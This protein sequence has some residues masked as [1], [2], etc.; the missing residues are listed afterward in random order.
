MLAVLPG[1]LLTIYTGEKGR[2]YA[3]IEAFEQARRLALLYSSN[4][5][6]IMEGGRQVLLAMAQYPSLKIQDGSCRNYFQSISKENP[7]F[8]N[9]IAVDREGRVFCSAARDVQ[10]V[11]V[12]D[13]EWFQ[14]T[15][16]RRDF[17]IGEPMASR[18]SGRDGMVLAYPIQSGSSLAAVAAVYLDMGWLKRL[19][20]SLPLPEGTTVS[21]VDRQGTFLTRFPDNGD[22]ADKSI[23][24]AATVLASLLEKGQDAV[25]TSGMDEIPRL[26]A[27]ASLISEPGNEFFVRIGIPADSAYAE[28]NKFMLRNLVMLGSVAL[29]I[30]LVTHFLGEAFVLKPVRVLLKAT[31]RLASG[32]MSFR[33]NV[34]PGGSELSQ[35]A[36]SFDHMA[37]S[38]ERSMKEIA[39]AEAKYRGLF[40][41][42]VE[43]IFRTTP[44]GHFLDANP[45][46]ARMFAYD[47]PQEMISQVKD[48]ATD[49]YVKSRDRKAIL[50]HLGLWGVVH[51]FAVEVRRQD[52]SVIW[53]SIDAQC[54]KDQA[55][56]VLAY[57]GFAVDITER[58]RLEEKLLLAKEE[59]EKANRAKS[60]FL[61]RMSHGIRTPMNSILGLTQ[62]T[63][64]TKLK[65]EQRDYLDTVLEAG[66]SLLKLVE[67]ILDISKIEAKALAVESTDFCLPRVISTT[68]NTLRVQA[69]N[70]GL[71]IGLTIDKG[72]PRYGK[73]DPGRLRQVIV[74]LVG[75]AIKF[76]DRGFVRLRVSTLPQ[77]MRHRLLSHDGTPVLF[78]IQ[79]TGPG[80]SPDKLE[81]VF[82]PFSKDTGLSLGPMAGPGLGLPICRELVAMMGGEIW[83]ESEP[84]LGSTFYF[85]ICLPPGDPVRAIKPPRTHVAARESAEPLR[86][87]VVEDNRVNSK[88]TSTYL[89]KMGHFSVEAANGQEAL[90]LLGRNTFDVVLMDLKMPEMDGLEATKAIKAGRAGEHNRDIPVVALTAHALNEIRETCL[91]AGMSD[92]LTKPVNYD[93]IADLLSR[94]RSRRPNKKHQDQAEPGQA[95][96]VASNVDWPAQKTAS[97][98][99]RVLIVDDVTAHREKLKDLLSGIGFDA[100]GAATGPEALDMLPRGFDLL[101][102][103]TSMPGMDGFAFTAKVREM[104]V[105]AGLPIIMVTNPS[106]PGERDRAFQ[107]GADDFLVKPVNP[108]EV[109]VRFTS[110]LKTREV[111]SR[112]KFTQANLEDLVRKRTEDLGKALENLT[113]LHQFAVEA[114]RETILCLSAAAEF[115]DEETAK[116]L[117]RMSEYCGLLAQKIGLAPQDAELIRLASPM[118]DVGKIGIPDSILFKPGKLDPEEWEVMRKHPLY[119][120]KILESSTSPIIQ[121][122]RVIALSHHER[123]DG[124]GY[125]YGLKEKDIPLFG[126]ICAVA[127][128]FDALTSNRPYKKAFTAEDSFRIMEEQEDGHFDPLLLQTFLDHRQEFVEIMHRLSD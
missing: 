29:L 13:Q 117:K 85:T 25:E 79:D 4:G 121:S 127:D 39:Q 81:S 57:E 46:M 71:D 43:G 6:A 107:A 62:I 108:T 9:I 95:E 75:N 126:R 109:R 78:A 15:L 18:I 113:D 14:R 30:L 2:G 96:T 16:A 24:K 92:F 37:D 10:N 60:D 119:G 31:K 59:A 32:D 20:E 58:K 17:T 101:L 87:L 42:A 111:L 67:D 49:V 89:R 63:L 116:H 56:N 128:V 66:E 114:N 27:F 12:S 5:R 73:G 7:E 36:H 38:L 1:I 47:T 22:W 115:K 34:A 118:H 122:A 65:E 97:E 102:V 84:G 104:P 21:V 68:L 110:L 55:G 40:E 26:Y 112:A 77:E 64:Q 50:D 123:W 8:S 83:M 93:D 103:E 125:P 41:N 76:T 53:I 3:R 45:A 88:L 72:V 94:F 11:S 124:R 19:T 69:R 48:L 51:D 52:G 28:S 61:T 44:E 74:N 54:K 106:D 90:D 70:K 120:A 100:V 91:K 99:Q 33:A 98:H 23:P 86:I 105:H 35:L 82:E 80:I